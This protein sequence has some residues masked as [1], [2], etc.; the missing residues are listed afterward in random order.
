MWLIRE[1]RALLLLY[2]N[3]E[4]LLFDSVECI[5]PETRGSTIFGMSKNAHALAASKSTMPVTLF[6]LIVFRTSQIED[7]VIHIQESPVPRTSTLLVRDI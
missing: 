4:S 5:K 7:R 2:E 3:R 1:I 6:V